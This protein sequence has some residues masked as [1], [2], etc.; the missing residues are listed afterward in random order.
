MSRRPLLD[1]LEF[2][3]ISNED[4]NW[5]GRPFEEEVLGV[6]QGFNGD[7]AP[8]PDGFSMDFFQACWVIVQN[9][10]MVVLRSFHVTGCQRSFHVTGCQALIPKKVGVVKERIFAPLVLL[11]GWI[12]FW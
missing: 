5:L 9:D 1:G 3:V 2:L 11:V 6:I 10:I 12:K 4:S 7:K 8:G